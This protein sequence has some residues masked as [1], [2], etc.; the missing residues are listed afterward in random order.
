MG[1]G[2]AGATSRQKLSRDREGQREKKER[3]RDG[4]VGD[5]VVVHPELHPRS[6][7]VAAPSSVPI[8]VPSCQWCALSITLAAYRTVYNHL[9]RTR[10][11][12]VGFAIK[13]ESLQLV[14]GG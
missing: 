12:Q 13:G 1:C 4:L 3:D 8:P 5:Q 11:L 6:A 14:V 2:L 7:E 10:S 9:P